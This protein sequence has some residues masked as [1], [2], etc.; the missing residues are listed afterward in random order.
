MKPTTTDEV[1]LYKKFHN[2]DEMRYENERERREAKR[3]WKRATS[4][5][6]RGE[7]KRL[8]RN[9]LKDI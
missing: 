7:E 8:I 3:V 2:E 1:Y 6:R 9:A 5:T 4:K